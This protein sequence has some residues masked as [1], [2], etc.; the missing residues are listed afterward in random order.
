[1]STTGGELG[2][3]DQPAGSPVARRPCTRLFTR[4]QAA[5]RSNLITTRGLYGVPLGAA[6]VDE[7]ALAE[8]SESQPAV[9]SFSSTRQYDGVEPA[10]RPQ[11]QREVVVCRLSGEC[12]ILTRLAVSS[13]ISS[14]IILAVARSCIV[15]MNSSRHRVLNTNCHMCNKPEKFYQSVSGLCRHTVAVPHC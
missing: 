4:S 13:A 11:E 14:D 15:K 3:A 2:P 9:G 1:M 6:P 8:L 10:V 5:A 7:L 12:E